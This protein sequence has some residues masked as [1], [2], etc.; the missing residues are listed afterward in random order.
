MHEYIGMTLDWSDESY[1]KVT[2][3]DFLEDILKE[4]DEKGDMKGTAATPALD[5]LF[6]VD[7]NLEKL[8]PKKADYY[9]RIVARLLFASKRARPDILTAVS[10]MCTRV[11]SPTKS[12]YNKLKRT[13][14][15][16]R[17]SIHLP[18]LLGWDESG[19]LTW[20]VDA[21]FAVHNDMKSH[22]GATVTMGKGGIASWSMKQKITTISSTEAELVGVDDA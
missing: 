10:Y 20:S 21:A 19:C 6:E 13:I 18:L 9:Y 22:T 1:I 5:K 4:V 14:T 7:E 12:D 15:Y 8:S 2:M 3:Y 17:Q 11:K 16:I